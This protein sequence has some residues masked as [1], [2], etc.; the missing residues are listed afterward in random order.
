VAIVIIKKASGAV[1]ASTLAAPTPIA[2]DEAKRAE[3]LSPIDALCEALGGRQRD[4][5]L[6]SDDM[7]K[8][9]DFLRFP[10][11]WADPDWICQMS[12]TPCD[13]GASMQYTGEGS[14]QSCLTFHTPT[15]PK[16]YVRK[17]T[18]TQIAFVICLLHALKDGVF[19]LR[20]IPA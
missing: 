1:K 12:K 5:G 16:S 3:P 13:W 6:T 14:A 11:A 10:G 18:S 17:A 2:A 9:E 7:D 15:W 4:D 19:V 8:V 20:D